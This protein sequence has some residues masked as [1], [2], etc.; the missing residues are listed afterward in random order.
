M[1][2]DVE[3]SSEGTTLRGHLYLPDEGEGPFPV[4]VMAGGWCYVKELVQPDYAKVFAAAGV[5]A[6]VFDYRY[7]GDSDGTPRQHLDPWKQI[8]D[9]KN[10]IS[11]AETRSELDSSRIGIWGISYSGGHVLVVGATDPRVKCIVSNIPV[12]DGLSTM[13]LVHGSLRFRELQELIAEDRRKR[14]ETGE[15]GVLPMSSTNPNDELVTWPFPE[16]TDAFVKLK[17][18]EAPNH[19]HFNTV[20][21]VELLLSYDAAGF[22]PRILNVPTLMTVA[23]KDDITMWDD[24]IR[25]YNSLSTAKKR[26]FI[27]DE[28]SH[29]TLY[30]NK[31]RLEVAAEQGRAWLVEHL[32]TPFA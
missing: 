28:T 31:S 19:E 20:E 26:L 1:R 12:I 13:R 7:M 4:V 10:A 16:V 18:T 22:A 6:L 5:A 24:E 11:Y 25:V 30:S 29:M 8:E 32:V 2:Q 21:S 14:F 3:F 17:E 27:F 15:G 23:E 9:Y